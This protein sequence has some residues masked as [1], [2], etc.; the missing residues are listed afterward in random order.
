MKA[1]RVTEFGAPEV[2]KLVESP[3]LKPDSGQILVEIKAIGVNP[4]EAYIRSGKYA[5]LPQLPYTPGND[6]AGIVKSI[7]KEV[8]QVKVG[9]KVFVTGSLTGTY[10]QQCL[11]LPDH[12]FS[13]PSNIDF[14][15]GAALGIPYGTAYRALFTKG[16]ATAK[17]TVLVHGGSGGVGMA[18][19]QLAKA[20]DMIVIATAGS[21][22]GLQL[23]K[24]Q[25]ADYVLDHTQAG[26]LDKI[27][28]ITAG[29][30]VDVVLE[31]LANINLGEDLKVA[32][33]GGRIIIIGCRGTVE[34]N[35]REAMAKDLTILGMLFT[36][37]DRDEK[38]KIYTAIQ[39]GIDAG[40][41][42]PVIGK[43]FSLAEAPL[44]H[45][46]IMEKGSQGKIVL[47]P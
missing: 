47:L 25:R 42:R 5:A 29:Q 6:A 15:Q 4:V 35:P 1:I 12:V 24:S 19:I 26:Y 38:R 18:A 9:E 32:A 30:G 39:T 44:S 36:N 20:N 17:E 41:L 31:M 46:A 34:I 45:H 2:L 28:E 8:R 3:E 23:L 13:L 16:R 33:R 43:Q 22:Q 27:K 11:C 7:G 14:A 10:A 21:E 37:T 40:Q